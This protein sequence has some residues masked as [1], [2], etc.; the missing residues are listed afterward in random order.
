MDPP[1][2]GAYT[3]LFAGFPRTD[4]GAYVIPWGRLHPRPRRDLLTHG[5]L[6]MKVELV[7]LQNSGTGA[8]GRRGSIPSDRI[9]FTGKAM[10]ID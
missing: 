10:E 2:L 6:R 1:E 7:A 3:E 5:S 9:P 8:M 4:N